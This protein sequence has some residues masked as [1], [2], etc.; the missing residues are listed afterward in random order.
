[1]KGVLALLCILTQFGLAVAAAEAATPASTPSPL[2]SPHP[3]IRPSQIRLKPLPKPSPKPPRVK[4]VHTKTK[5]PP[6]PLVLAPKSLMKRAVPPPPTGFILSKSS[7]G[8]LLL[9][10]YANNPGF[11]FDTRAPFVIQLN[12]NEPLKL[13]PSVITRE[14]WPKGATQMVLNYQS[15]STTKDNVILGKA[16]YTVCERKTKECR[17]AK[18]PIELRFR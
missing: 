8:K 2:P 7:A 11:D 3:R 9:K 10:Y 12:V 18:V 16:A 14:N 5:T 15:A 6:Q 1:M 4:G 17:R 13:N